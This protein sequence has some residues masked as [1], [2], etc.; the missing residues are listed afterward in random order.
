[1]FAL[2]SWHITKTPRHSNFLMFQRSNIPQIVDRLP[3]ARLENLILLLPMRTL[4]SRAIQIDPSFHVGLA[5]IVLLGLGEIFFGTS[6]YVGRARAN[7][8]VS[9]TMANTIASPPPA[10][11]Y[12]SVPAA[13]QPTVSKPVAVVSPPASSVADRLLREGKELREHGDTTNAL[14]RFQQ[15]L[16][17]EPDNASVLEEMA[18]TYEAMQLLDRANDLWRRIKQI[19]PPDSAMYELADQRLKVGV[20]STAPTE[21]AST[22]SE[23][24]IAPP[25]DIGGNTD[26]PVMGISEVKT[27]VTPDPDAETNMAL[28]IGIK[29]EPGAVVDHDKVK[30]LVFLYDI[31]SDKDIK[32]TDADVTNEWV[33][34]KHDWSD[35]NPEVLM[36]RYVRAK[37]GGALSESSLSEAA[38]KV[39]PGQKSRG[40]KSAADTGQRKYLGYIVRVY[41]DD[42]LQAV[43]AEPSRLLQQFPPSKNPSAQ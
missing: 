3:T 17:S 12:S 27:K 32:L 40:S 7:R 33:T 18:Q 5:L 30:I 21:P 13:A 19:S 26:G 25:K 16:D 4:L 22:N 35:T 28:E 24:D 36:V 23:T 29:K 34:T 10:S 42:E 8:V 6:Y 20:P 43:Q 39:R 15:A 14:A 38:A 11:A 9:H 37:T 41:Y 31:V 2:L 1:M